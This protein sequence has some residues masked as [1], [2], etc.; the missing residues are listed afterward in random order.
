MLF[1]WIT[2]R[3]GKVKKGL[4][5]PTSQVAKTALEAGILIL[6]P[7]THVSWFGKQEQICLVQSQKMLSGD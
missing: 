2:Q 4:S 5:F 1:S 3:N 6:Y 7:Q